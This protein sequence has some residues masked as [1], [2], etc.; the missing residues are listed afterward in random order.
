MQGIVS[1]CEEPVYIQY[2]ESHGRVLCGG[3]PRSNLCF[4]RKLKL[5][6]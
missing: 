3:V 1:H 6:Y 5:Q 4:T 2:N